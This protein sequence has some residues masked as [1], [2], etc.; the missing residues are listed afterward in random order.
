MFSFLLPL[1][2][3]SVLAR[4]GASGF[5]GSSVLSAFCSGFASAT[6]SGSGSGFGSGSCSVERR[7]EKGSAEDERRT[8]LQR[9]RGTAAAAAV[10]HVG[11]AGEPLL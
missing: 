11:A 7:K 6:G 10:L 5:F 2:L 4:R 1:A 3:S 9:E 8:A